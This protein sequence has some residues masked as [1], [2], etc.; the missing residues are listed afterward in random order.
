MKTNTLTILLLMMSLIIAGRHA[1]AT[2]TDKD[3]E[4][5]DMVTVL[6]AEYA[7]YQRQITGDNG[8]GDCQAT[9]QLIAKAKEILEKPIEN[10]SEK[11]D[12]NRV[13]CA[14]WC[15]CLRIYQ[16]T[17]SQEVKNTILAHW[18][19]ALKNDDNVVPF[20]IYALA[21]PLAD[22]NFMTEEFWKLFQKTIQKKTIS[23][24]SYIVFCLG[25]EADMKRL[26]QKRDSGIDFDLQGVIQRTINNMNYRFGCDKTSPGPAQGPPT[27][28]FEDESLGRTEMII[29]MKAILV[30]ASAEDKKKMD[31]LLD[32]LEN[33]L[34]KEN[35]SLS[36]RLAIDYVAQAVLIN[37]LDPQWKRD[38][39]SLHSPV[40]DPN[41]LPV[42]YDNDR[43]VNILKQCLDNNDW[44]VRVEAIR[45]LGAIG[46]NDLKKTDDIV[47]SLN[48][49][50]DKEKASEE[51]E[52]VKAS[53]EA[54]ILN[55]LERINQQ[56]EKIKETPKETGMGGQHTKPAK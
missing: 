5:R 15:L 56:I 52:K 50:I 51:T 11:E 41:S 14:S 34:K 30:T 45:W 8:L 42:P 19:N 25:D 9:F 43:A 21:G 13:Y 12:R 27:R 44:K 4:I 46:A 22:R 48:A 31:K 40:F 20:Q 37:N 29:P 49:Q 28:N 17:N 18:N 54:D 24:I 38:L 36:R 35:P 47:A 55:S 23:A 1:A 26:E 33:E 10:K 6:P 2:M 32:L 7:D 16:S 3:M 53:R 39:F